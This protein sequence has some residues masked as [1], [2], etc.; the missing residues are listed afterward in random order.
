[1]KEIDTVVKDI[2]KPILKN[3]SPVILIMRRN[4]N[5]L[6]GEKYYEFCEPERILFK[7]DKKN[8]ATL[9]IK[10]FNSVISFYIE[11][12]K[13][14]ILEK[15]NS[16]FGYN[17][18]GDIKIK[19]DPRIIKQYKKPLPKIEDGDLNKINSVITDVEN[20]ELKN[21]LKDFGNSLF[22]KKQK[23]QL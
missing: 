11:N 10:C 8:D 1:M 12:N 5:T 13:M 19:Q 14:F 17:L 23:S 2:L 6:I 4:W 20:E 18:I 15:I 16:I 7:K 9:Y 22:T 21:A 3:Y